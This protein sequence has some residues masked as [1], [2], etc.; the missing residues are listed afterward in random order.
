M[1][2][3][4]RRMFSGAPFCREKRKPGLSGAQALRGCPDKGRTALPVASCGALFHRAYPD[5]GGAQRLD[6]AGQAVEVGFL[7]DL[8]V[9]IG[10]EQDGLHVADDLHG[11]VDGHGV[12]LV[13][14]QKGDVD[15]AQR[16]HFGGR[17]RVAGNV[18]AH[19]ADGKQVS[20]V[21][22][23]LGVELEAPLG[24]VVGGDGF[25]LHVVARRGD[26]AGA[27]DVAL[28]VERLG[29]GAVAE[30]VGLRSAELLDGGEVEVVVVRMGQQD[31]VGLGQR[32]GED[33]AAAHGIDIDMFAPD[34]DR[35]RRMLE[36]CDR[37]LGAV[38]R[39]QRVGG[40][41][42]SLGAAAEEREKCHKQ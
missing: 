17:L 4:A 5:F 31:E 2:R 26:A 32:G 7:L 24:R 23:L 22:A 13:D 9:V 39:D 33:V 16:F 19:A 12:G 3:Q 27:H 35:E 25:D 41:D 20:A 29:R 36:E 42:G 15:I 21:L 1:K 8:P 34:V 18:D 38:V 40:V 30:D 11:L 14:G 37:K 10:I 6:F 28:H